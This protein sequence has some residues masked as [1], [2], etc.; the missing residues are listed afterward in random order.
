MSAISKDCMRSPDK[1]LSPTGLCFAKSNIGR[2]VSREGWRAR[3]VFPVAPTAE[4]RI[5]AGRSTF[6]GQSM[7]SKVGSMYAFDFGGA[8]EKDSDAYFR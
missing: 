3:A 8:W 6:S 4:I 5:T 1:V 7:L 2:L